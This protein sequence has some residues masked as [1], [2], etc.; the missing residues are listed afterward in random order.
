MNG[1]LHPLFSTGSFY[2]KNNGLQF[3]FKLM[4][5]ELSRS[6]PYNL[7]ALLLQEYNSFIINPSKTGIGEVITI[8]W[9]LN[10]PSGHKG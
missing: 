1:K 6:V 2:F 7:E 9:T 4:W 10:K 8:F 3:T 5:V